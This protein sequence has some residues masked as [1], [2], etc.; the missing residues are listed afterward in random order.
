MGG[1]GNCPGKNN[2][3]LQVLYP[4]VVFGPSNPGTFSGAVG[5]GHRPVT[6]TGEM[7]GGMTAFGATAS[8]P[9]LLQASRNDTPALS[10]PSSR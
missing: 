2:A 3:S 7:A 6:M 1:G 10:H 9:Q 5:D 4:E 8:H